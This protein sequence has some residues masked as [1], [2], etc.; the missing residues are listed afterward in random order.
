MIIIVINIINILINIVFIW[1]HKFSRFY[2]SSSLV[3]ILLAEG[4][5][6]QL[7]GAWLLADVKL[8]Q[9]IQ[10]IESHTKGDKGITVLDDVKTP[11]GR[12]TDIFSPWQFPGMD[13][14]C[15]S[16]QIVVVAEEVGL[17]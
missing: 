5:S 9:F 14:R 12:N 16:C 13:S 4:V 7:C 11:A 1:T 8:G 15:Y 10:L 17:A 2:S 3:P 6:E